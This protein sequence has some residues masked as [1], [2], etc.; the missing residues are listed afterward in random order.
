MFCSVKNM[1]EALHK[2]PKPGSILIFSCLTDI[3]HLFVR[4]CVVMAVLR[5]L[6]MIAYV[7][8][9]GASGHRVQKVAVSDQRVAKTELGAP[10]E[11]EMRKE[12]VKSFKPPTVWMPTLDLK[13]LVMHKASRVLWK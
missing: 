11:E 5:L 12:A 13:K 4:H 10:E 1:Q 8:L 7:A 3:L 2:P 6:W 9:H